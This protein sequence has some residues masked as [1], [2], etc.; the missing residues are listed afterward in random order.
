MA[1][2]QLPGQS[3]PSSVAASA[4]LP[5]SVGASPASPTAA[6]PARRPKKLRRGAVSVVPS[7]LFRLRLIIGSSMVRVLWLLEFAGRFHRHDGPF[8]SREQDGSKRKRT[9][10]G[11]GCMQP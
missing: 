8:V 10:V 6:A 3:S 9:P 11:A 1:P 4:C 5:P 2:L 7:L